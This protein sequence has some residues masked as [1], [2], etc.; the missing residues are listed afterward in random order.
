MDVFP[1]NFQ[2]EVCEAFQAT[3]KENGKQL[4]NKIRAQIHTDLSAKGWCI[5][6]FD[7]HDTDTTV[8]RGMRETF[9]KETFAAL[10]DATF[11]HQVPD[12][13]DPHDRNSRYKWENTTTDYLASEYRIHLPN[14]G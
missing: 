5:F 1:K 14:K 3:R 2:K 11:E 7:G 13:D 9:V 4:T 12:D 6:N 10:P 8:P